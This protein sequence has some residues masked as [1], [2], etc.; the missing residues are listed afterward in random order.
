MCVVTHLHLFA[1]IVCGECKDAR[2]ARNETDINLDTTCYQWKTL[3]ETKRIKEEERT[4]TVTKKVE[5]KGSISDLIKECEAILGRYKT[6]VQ[7]Q[8]PVPVPVLQITERQH[9]PNV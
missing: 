7:H 6:R 3:K 4:V 1:C 9:A 8:P 2:M 5:I